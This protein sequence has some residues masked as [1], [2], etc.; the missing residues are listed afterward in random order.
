M[1]N[2]LLNTAEKVMDILKSLPQVNDCKLYGSLANGT[3]DELSDIDIEID[4]SG[5]DNGRFMMELE[6]LLSDRLNIIFS[7]Y[8][9]SLVP[10]KY[11][12]SLAIDEDNP[13]LILDLYC[14]AEPHCSTVSKQQA[15][16]AN[17]FY[18]HMLKLWVANLKHYFRGQD[19]YD[20][21]FRMASKLG[22]SNID[23]KNEAELLECVLI[24]L[25]NNKTIQ[26]E[27]YILS[28][29]ESFENFV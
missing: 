24:W 19:C 9:P 8:A 13:F 27:R 2:W 11:I 22:I 25:E 1:N 16:S 12:V 26:T 21:I 18:T 3:Y 29:R 4:V 20:D 17:D 14:T 28:C 6:S 5:Y 10:D 23:A 7:D 15:M